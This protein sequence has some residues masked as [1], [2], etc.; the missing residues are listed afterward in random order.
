MCPQRDLDSAADTQG[1]SNETHHGRKRVFRSDHTGLTLDLYWLR[2]KAGPGT[3]SATETCL[4]EQLGGQLLSSYGG[5][6]VR[7]RRLQCGILSL[8]L[9]LATTSTD[10]S[11]FPSCF[12]FLKS[13]TAAKTPQHQREEVWRGLRTHKYQCL[14]GSSPHCDTLN[15]SIMSKWS[16]NKSSQLSFTVYHPVSFGL[17]FTKCLIKTEILGNLN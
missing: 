8:H 7:T 13:W 10:A 9:S 12:C 15:G 2:L 5:W 16:I 1:D 6:H 11:H 17:I 3:G 4:R 14:F